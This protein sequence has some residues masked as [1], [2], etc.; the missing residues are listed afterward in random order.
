MFD[1]AV[2]N[3]GAFKNSSLMFDGSVGND[4]AFKN[5]SL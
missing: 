4:G 3:D 1:G 2:G 5:S